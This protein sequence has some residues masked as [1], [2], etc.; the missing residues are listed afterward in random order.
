M[1]PVV[2]AYLAASLLFLIT[3]CASFPQYRPIQSTINSGASA[4]SAVVT[5]FLLER[6]LPA[7]MERIGTVTIHTFGS[8]YSTHQRVEDELQ[9][10]GRQKGAT[11][12]YRIQ[13][14]TYDHDKDGLITYLLFR[15]TK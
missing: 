3:G 6:D 7:R 2:S 11:G 13:H 4:D 8:L 14:G 15:Y 5:V 9:K 1:K 12:A 10:L